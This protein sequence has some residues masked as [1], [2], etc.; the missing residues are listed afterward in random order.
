ML[1]GVLVAVTLG[2]LV[3][4]EP[5]ADVGVRVG[6]RVM[7]GVRVGVAEGGGATT[8]TQFE[9]S[10]VLPSGSVAVEVTTWPWPRV[11]A[12]GTVAVKLALPLPSVEAVV[13]PRKVLPWPWAE[14][15]QPGFEKK[16]MPNV[17]FGVLLRVPMMVVEPPPEVAADNTG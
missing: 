10:D 5:G 16:S 2:V 11:T 9:N 8:V 14:T 4:V 12:T 7:V 17:M 3:K 13:L 6:V 15:S 1:V